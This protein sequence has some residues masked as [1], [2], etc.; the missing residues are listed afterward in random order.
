MIKLYITH[1][2]S[3]HF[4]KIPTLPRVDYRC[5]NLA[6]SEMREDFEDDGLFDKMA[7][8]FN[9]LTI[10]DKDLEIDKQEMEAFEENQKGEKRKL[11]NEGAKLQGHIQKLRILIQT[12]ST[13][14]IHATEKALRDTETRFSVIKELLRSIIQNIDHPIKSIDKRF[15]KPHRGFIMYGPPGTCENT[16]KLK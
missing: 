14:D 2:L 8:F 1:T 11:E 7:D 13:N 10:T 3:L 16:E 5:I 6:F 4:D 15:R 12:R 9:P